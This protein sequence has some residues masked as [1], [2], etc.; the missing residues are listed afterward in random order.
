LSLTAR[1]IPQGTLE[2]KT[3]VSFVWSF[4]VA[5]LSVIVA[6]G[7]QISVA[8]PTVATSL[9]LKKDPQL[10][11]RDHPWG[12]DLEWLIPTPERV[13]AG[14]QSLPDLLFAELDYR[15]VKTLQALY[16]VM[17]SCQNGFAWKA[18]LQ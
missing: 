7:V 16:S 14:E 13:W 18:V 17:I 12:A 15:L 11:C 9:A 2:T 6:I 10:C 8:T 4:L 1:A 5:I 3:L